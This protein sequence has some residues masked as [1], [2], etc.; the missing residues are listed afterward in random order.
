[1]ESDSEDLILLNTS[2]VGR[3]H[4]DYLMDAMAGRF[5]RNV[6]KQVR[7]LKE[8][9]NQLVGAFFRFEASHTEGDLQIVVNARTKVQEIRT[10]LV[11]MRREATTEDDKE[12]D[13]A[14]KSANEELARVGRSFETAA[15]GTDRSLSLTSIA[16]T[17]LVGDS[18]WEPVCNSPP[19]NSDQVV[20]TTSDHDSIIIDAVPNP[21]NS[22]QVEAEVND[23]RLN[24]PVY[25]PPGFAQLGSL[26][27]IRPRSRP[28]SSVASQN[29]AER[30][31]RM[32]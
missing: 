9:T 15:L 8:S 28:A 19:T 32:S 24:H 4:P 30:K 11:R 21:L 22:L 25:P 3:L 2:N 6:Q 23:V 13:V 14:I 27:S 29:E 17:N 7:N 31:A 1:M 20:R 10:H 16:S 18:F 12:S 5:K 26:S